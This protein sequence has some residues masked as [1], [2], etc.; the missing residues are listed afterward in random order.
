MKTYEE[1]PYVVCHMLSAV[2]GRIDGEYFKAPELVPVRKESDRIRE[3]YGCNAVLCGAVTA[4]EIYADGF[5]PQ[6]ERNTAGESIR[7]DYVASRVPRDFAVC[8]DTEGRL[9]WKSNT[10]NRHRKTFHVVEVLTED[11]GDGYL[12]FLEERDISYIF[13][14]WLYR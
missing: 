12:R 7:E 6:A 3:E 10:V 5:L 14:G 13:A 4:A 9:N 11:V 2:N 1:R 8:I